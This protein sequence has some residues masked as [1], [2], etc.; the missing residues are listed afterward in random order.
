MSKGPVCVAILE[1]GDHEVIAE[2]VFHADSY[3]YR[4]ADRQLMPSDRFKG[5]V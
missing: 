1:H 5:L 4:G 2:P 3:G